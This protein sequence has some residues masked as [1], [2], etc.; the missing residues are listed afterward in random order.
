MAQTRITGVL[1]T[2]LAHQL[3]KAD[4]LNDGETCE[5]MATVAAQ[6]R[7]LLGRAE[8]ALSGKPFGHQPFFINQRAGKVFVVRSR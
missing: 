8:S 4:L 6:A 3:F 2:W 7:S 1:F 5:G